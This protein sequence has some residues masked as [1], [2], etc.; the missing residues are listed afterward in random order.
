MMKAA[1]L[2]FDKAPLRLLRLFSS[3]I[4]HLSP[5]SQLLNRME[6]FG[7]MIYLMKRRVNSL[8]YDDE[9]SDVNQSIENNCRLYSR[10]KLMQ[11]YPS[12]KKS[13]HASTGLFS[14][15]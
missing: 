9:D 7:V 6:N 14:D 12:K 3:H 4:K 10:S 2:S 1:L 11:F 8:A 15:F 5:F 13:K